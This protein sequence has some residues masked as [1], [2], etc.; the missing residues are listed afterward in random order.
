MMPMIHEVHIVD[1]QNGHSPSTDCWCE[2]VAI[3]LRTDP[4]GNLTRFV[5]HVDLA[6]DHRILVVA[7]RERDKLIISASPP[8]TPWGIDNPWITR[9]LDNLHTE[10]PDPNERNL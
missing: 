1:H 8:G 4:D 5:E 2:P 9:A 6:N 7:T 10:P 3:S